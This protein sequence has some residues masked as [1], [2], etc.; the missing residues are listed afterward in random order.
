MQSQYFVLY[1]LGRVSY[2]QYTCKASGASSYLAYISL[3]V[4][5]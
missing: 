3:T 2:M 4:I 5:C 1:I